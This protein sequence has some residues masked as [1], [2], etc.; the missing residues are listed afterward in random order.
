LL[1]LNLSF[2][3]YNPIQWH[4]PSTKLSKSQNFFVEEENFG[5]KI[6]KIV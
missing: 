2:S 1:R 4:T 3:W 6:G 5:E